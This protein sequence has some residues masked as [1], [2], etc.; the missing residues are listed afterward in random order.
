MQSIDLVPDTI[1]QGRAVLTTRPQ[2]AEFTDTLKQL[3]ANRLPDE[4]GA[5]CAGLGL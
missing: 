2:R 5:V 1:A 3:M 4:K